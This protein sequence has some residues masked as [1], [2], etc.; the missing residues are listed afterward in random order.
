MIGC[1]PSFHFPILLAPSILT[2][3]LLAPPSF[4]H[5]QASDARGRIADF[6]D[7]MAA[8]PE[9]M[10][11]LSGGAGGSAFLGLGGV[12]V[13][14]APSAGTQARHNQA[15]SGTDNPIRSNTVRARPRPALTDRM[16]CSPVRDRLEC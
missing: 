5:L 1:L 14:A 7:N 11:G 13:R 15:E 2:K 3:A 4:R 8:N 16:R 10:Q 6:F 9:A 12:R